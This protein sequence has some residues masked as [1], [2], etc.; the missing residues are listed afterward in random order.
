ML[1]LFLVLLLLLLL[2]LLLIFF[3]C[4]TLR[5]RVTIWLFCIFIVLHFA[6]T[7]MVLK[8]LLCFHMKPFNY[9]AKGVR[10]VELACRCH[11]SN[12]MP[13]SMF[14]V[15]IAQCVTCFFFCLFCFVLFYVYNKVWNSKL[16]LLVETGC[17]VL[18]LFH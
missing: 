15:N 11:Q 2:L 12:I 9:C 3:F 13:D 10:D 5:Y 1:L 16:L 18:L 4:H 17:S 6:T 7:L 14:S 8:P